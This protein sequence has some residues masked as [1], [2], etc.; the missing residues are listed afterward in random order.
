MNKIIKYYNPHPAKKNIG[1]CQTRAFV[2]LTGQPY[3][4]VR[5][6]LNIIK[7]GIGAKNYFDTAVVELAALEFGSYKDAIIENKTFENFAKRNKGR[8][9]IS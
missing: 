7:K 6:N 3:L 2:K 1:D 4:I 8:F 9:F 5:K